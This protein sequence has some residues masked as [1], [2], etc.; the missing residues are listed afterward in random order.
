MDPLRDEGLAYAEALEAAG[1]SV[2]K[3]V[4]PGLPHGCESHE[5]SLERLALTLDSLHVSAAKSI[6]QIRIQRDR[7]HL[8]G[9]GFWEEQD[10]D[11]GDYSHKLP[12]SEAQWYELPCAVQRSRSLL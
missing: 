7:I 5:S 4:Y 2:K 11:R 9:G 1:V 6:G 12:L 8:I 10:I 3:E